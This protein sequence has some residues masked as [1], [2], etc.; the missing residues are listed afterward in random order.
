[1][2]ELKKYLQENSYKMDTDMPS[3]KLFDRI[4]T[5]TAGSKKTGAR[6]ITFRFAAAACIAAGIFT[7]IKLLEKN[8]KKEEPATVVK[9]AQTNSQKEDNLITQAPAGTLVPDLTAV[10]TEKNLTSPKTAPGKKQIPESY[11]LLH[12][13]EYNY[14]RLV[15]L[16][17]KMIRQTPLYEETTGCFNDFKYALQ[18]IDRDE[19]AIKTTIKK[20][21]LNDELLEQL[22]NVYQGKID[23]L[24]SLQ[25]EI[26]RMNT[27]IKNN[28]Q[29][30]DSMKT[31]FINI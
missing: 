14:T 20:S 31:Y 10:N 8:T 15:N 22:I 11:Q 19:A 18:Q 29:P 12:S 26:A 28:S 1:M 3:D 6:T 27:K 16:Q 7:G 17:L 2:D 21:G 4:K 13:F 9:P 5:S 25:N 24:K 30:A 23:L